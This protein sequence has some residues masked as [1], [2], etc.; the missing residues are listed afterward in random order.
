MAEIRIGLIG[1]TGLGDALGAEN[2]ERHAVDT[3]FGPPSSE[4]ITTDWQ[5]VDVVI[6]QRHGAGHVHNPSRVPY[7][8]NIYAMKKLGVTHIIGSGACGSLREPIAPKD[9]VIP[10]QIIDKT[11][12]RDSTFYESAA[13]HVEL[14]DPYCPVMRKW[15]LHAAKRL[16]NDILVHERGTYVCME[17]PA[18]S[19]RAES[20]MHQAWGG[21]LIGMTA[22]PEAKLAREAEIAYAQVA[23][24]TD[25]D[26]WRPHD[27][28]ITPQQLLEEIIGNL[29]EATQRSIRLIRLALE[30]LSILR[31]DASPAHHALKLAIWSDKSRIPKEEVQRLA[32]LW[33][34]Y[35][36]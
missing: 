3:P 31:S 8:A 35:F 19:T 18:F 24:A 14:S 20:Q 6:L 16:D 27:P 4:I 29:Q 13:V 9:L 23:L 32:P 28:H 22:M 33:G 21:D 7:R 12:K 5:G 1:G 11:H 34:Q 17:G 2:G 26:C 36:E 25:Y 10:D 15:L 30:D